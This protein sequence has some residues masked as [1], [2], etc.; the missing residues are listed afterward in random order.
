MATIVRAPQYRLPAWFQNNRRLT[1][2]WGTTLIIALLFPLMLN[3]TGHIQDITGDVVEGEIYAMLALGLNVVV[4]FAGLLDLGYAAFFAIGAY[5]F[6]MLSSSHFLPSSSFSS[7]FISWGPNGIHANFWFFLLA[8]AMLA[9][10]F[11]LIL[12]APTLRLRGDYLAIVTLGFG[13]IVH[14]VV[15]NLG[16]GSTIN[17]FGW[18]D[19]TGGTNSLDGIFQPSFG[20]VQFSTDQVPWYYLGL[21][22][23]AVIIVIA[24]SLQNSRLGRA[25]V[26]M[27]EDELAAAC[28]GINL[29]NTKLLAFSMGAF[30]SGFA[31]VVQGSRLTLVDPSQFTFQIS[32]SILVM[33]VLGGIGSVPGVV[34]GAGIIA[35]LQFYLL[36]QLNDWMHLAGTTANIGLLQHI[37][38]TQAQYLI[39]GIMLVIMMIFRREGLIPSSQRRRELRPADESVLAEENQSLYTVRSGE[40]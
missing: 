37:D 13:E 10:L 1:I 23:L 33:V 29:R 9:A 8:C 15:V 40:A 24:Y 39:F 18:P 20:P 26:A 36:H 12:G 35:L 38:L 25:W 32:I 3:P 5:S 14:K 11:G 34:L 7:P 21:G 6:G 30:F 2:G 28:M 4:G 17:A 27:R 22:V 16:P 19:I 31:G